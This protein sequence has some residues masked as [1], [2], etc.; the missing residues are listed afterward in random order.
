[1]LFEPPSVEI[2]VRRTVASDDAN[3]SGS[4]FGDDVE[5]DPLA[6]VVGGIAVTVFAKNCSAVSDE[7]SNATTE[8][9]VKDF[10][11]AAFSILT[12]RCVGVDL[13]GRRVI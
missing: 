8:A 11:R 7:E 4:R 6:V 1:L 12:K 9:V 10:F 5:R 2:F 13:K 3:S